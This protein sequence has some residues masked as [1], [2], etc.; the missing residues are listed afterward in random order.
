M[1]AAG[2]GR[3]YSSRR[4]LRSRHCGQ[5]H[6]PLRSDKPPTDYRRGKQHHTI[7]IANR[8]RGRMEELQLRY[9]HLAQITGFGLAR[10]GNYTSLKEQINRTPDVRG[11]IA[12]L[13]QKAEA[14]QTRM[15]SRGR[16]R[17]F[18]LRWRK[19]DF[20]RDRP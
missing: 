18:N 20:I 7:E 15:T 16:D 17:H 12:A 9:N 10:I 19:N 3:A 1:G 6:L 4:E 5:Q 8:L 2:I 14:R 11:L 13:R